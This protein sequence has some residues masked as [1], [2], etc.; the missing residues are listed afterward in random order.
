MLLVLGEQSVPFF[1]S[2]FVS[3][4]LL[5]ELLKNLDKL[6]LTAEALHYRNETSFSS[7]LK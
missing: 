3:S 1:L 2:V 5:L 7:E 4:V 6:W